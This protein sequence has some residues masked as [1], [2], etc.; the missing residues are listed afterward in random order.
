MVFSAASEKDHPR[1]LKPGEIDPLPEA[2]PACPDPVDMGS[3]AA[4]PLPKLSQSQFQAR[5]RVWLS[6]ALVTGSLQ[7]LLDVVLC[8]L[9]YKMPAASQ[10]WCADEHELSDLLVLLMA[11]G[12]S[13][14]QQMSLKQRTARSGSDDSDSS[15]DDAADK[16]QSSPTATTVAAVAAANARA[17]ITSASASLPSAL[18]PDMKATDSEEYPVTDSDLLR[19][20]GMPSR[21]VL[22]IDLTCALCVDP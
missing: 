11:F 16:K 12:G 10:Q 17:S 15:E 5:L 1:R 9:T 4:R 7:L 3:S 20:Y 2:K 14:Q 21:L 22:R 8:M 19:V 13:E 6:L 18:G